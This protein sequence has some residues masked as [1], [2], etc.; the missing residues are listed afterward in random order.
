MKS[1]KAPIAP[2][3]SKLDTTAPAAP[4]VGGMPASGGAS[5]GGEKVAPQ[6][7]PDHKASRSPNMR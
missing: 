1:K 7:Y 5:G 3:G 6:N 4:R 2:Q